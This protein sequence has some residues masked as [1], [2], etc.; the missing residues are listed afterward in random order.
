MS[1]SSPLSAISLSLATAGWYSSR[2]PTISSRPAAS[3]AATARSADSTSWAS[4]FSTKQCLPASSTRTASSAWVGTGVARTTA[5]SSGSP[6]RSSRSPVRLRG[7]DPAPTRSS[8]SGSASHSHATSQSAM[9]GEVAGEVRAPVA[10]ARDAHLDRGHASI[11]RASAATTRSPAWPSPYRGGR[12]AGGVALERRGG[13]RGVEID[14]HVPARVDRLRPLRRRAHR[15]AGHAGEVGLLLDA[16]RVR[17]HRTG[18]AQQRG[19]VEVAERRREHGRP[20]PSASRSPAASS[21]AAVR[22]CS[23]R[24]TGPWTAAQERRRARRAAR[25]RRRCRRDGP[26]RA[27][28]GRAPRRAASSAA[29]RAAARGP[30]SCAT[31][32]IT[33][34]TT[35][36]SPGHALAAQDRGGRLRGAQQQVA[37]VVGQ[38]AVELLGHRAVVGAHPRLDVR[39]RHPGLCGGERAGQRRVRVAV[40]EHE[41][42]VLAPRSAGRARRASGRSAPCC[43]RR[44]ARGGARAAA[45]RARRRRPARAPRRSAGP[46][47]RA[48]RRPPR[49]AA[50][51]PPRP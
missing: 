33:S 18:V 45:A 27:R 25:G 24:T 6:S 23:G 41:R 34:P 10:E 28:S 5:S 39:D 29:V 47:G 43:S 49:G 21:R 2:W 40:D 50:P 14:E 19:E 36:T 12:S 9:R 16:A 30:S 7:R 15:H 26:S 51:R 22:G 1:P 11:L 48:P 44:R 35:S 8:A 46:C 4:G 3:A 32:T 38:H 31:S 37:R 42:G 20:A 17:E 13:R